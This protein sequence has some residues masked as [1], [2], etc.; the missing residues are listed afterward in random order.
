MLPAPWGA[1]FGGGGGFPKSSP[2]FAAGRLAGLALVLL[3][4]FGMSILVVGAA[5]AAGGAERLD[6]NTFVLYDGAIGD[7]PDAHNLNFTNLPLGGA[8]QEFEDG[9]TTL[10]STL[11]GETT[12][13]GYLAYPAIL[14]EMPVLD[15]LRG[16]QVDLTLLISREVHARYNRAGFSLIVLGNDATG[17]ELG[18][19]ENEIWA[20]HDDSTG[21][22]FTHGEGVA[23][24]TTTGLT[25]YSVIVQGNTYTL[26]AEG[27]AILSGPIRDY[28]A[29]SGLIDP[30]ET[31]NFLFLGDDTTSAGSVIGLSYVAVTTDEPPASPTP[32]ATD[33]PPS[34][35]RLIYRY[36]PVVG[37]PDVL[38]SR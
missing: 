3:L 1:G 30:Y 11:E 20:Q 24:D 36:L 18:F 31:E 5:V 13:A 34:P 10:D 19:W 8:S 14:A 33:S 21:A 37:R 32:A 17:I 16:Y 26:T 15:R 29:F 22:L 4:G 23:F 12:Y 28:T 25:D 27:E 9:V 2:A 35:R 7:T 6:E 38:R